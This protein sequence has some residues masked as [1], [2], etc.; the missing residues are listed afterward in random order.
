MDEL[1]VVLSVCMS[2]ARLPAC[3]P[4]CRSRC[5]GVSYHPQIR[6]RRRDNKIK[7][8]QP[9]WDWCRRP[10]CSV[11]IVSY[12]YCRDYRFRHRFKV[13]H[14]CRL[15]PVVLL[16]CKKIMYI[17]FNFLLPSHNDV[18]Q[19]VRSVWG[20][21]SDRIHCRDCYVNMHKWSSYIKI[22]SYKKWTGPLFLA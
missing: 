20:W 8:K 6:Y 18:I 14:R 15:P 12:C 21:S 11:A 7:G 17:Y 9:Q 19:S 3:L 4:D 22:L 2:L 5:P 1:L 13:V 10:W 16:A